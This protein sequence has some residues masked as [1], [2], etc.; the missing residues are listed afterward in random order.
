MSEHLEPVRLNKHLKD[1]G[2]CSRR[3]ADEFISKGYIEVNGKIVTELGFKVSPQTDII[4][5][6]S[7][8]E[9]EITQFRYLLLNKP[10]GYVCTKSDIDGENIFALVPAIENLTYAGRLDKD[11]YGLII[12]SNDGKFVYSIAGSDFAKEKEY[13]VTVNKEITRNFLIQQSNGSIRLDGKMVQKAKVELINNYTYR[14]I[15]KEGINRQ[16]RRMAENQGYKV[17]DLKRVRIDQVTDA[18]L[19]IGQWRDLLSNEINLLRS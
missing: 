5:V 18:N 10:R 6:L 15:L 16:I 3:K 8:V 7:Q 13:I 9:Q 12:L 2:I 11:S 17:I 14:I 1:L 19:A 4:K